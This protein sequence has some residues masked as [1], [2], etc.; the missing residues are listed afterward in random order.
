MTDRSRLGRASRLKGKTG[1]RLLL[2]ALRER[3]IDCNRTSEFAGDIILLKPPTPELARLRN[4]WLVEA[5]YRRSVNL[6]AI[7]AELS[8][9]EGLTEAKPFVAWRETRPGARREWQ[10][11][12]L[13]DTL[14]AL[15]DST[16]KASQPIFMLTIS[17][18]GFSD[19]WRH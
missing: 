9:V 15:I 18:D 14:C 7:L 2:A 19:L 17:L 5:K 13:S 3:G 16:P 4:P 6:A 10:V 1:E 8:G 12:M 11:S